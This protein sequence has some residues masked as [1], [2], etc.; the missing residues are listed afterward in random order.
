MQLS[1]FPKYIYVLKLFFI[2]YYSWKTTKDIKLQSPRENS[3]RDDWKSGKIL[4]QFFFLLEYFL[5]I[6]MQGTLERFNLQ[7][8]KLMFQILPIVMKSFSGFTL[9]NTSLKYDIPLFTKWNVFTSVCCWSKKS[10][11]HWTKN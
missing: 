7:Y 4:V 2:N 11:T 8:S 5:I 9:S 10:M 6:I 3:R 1:T